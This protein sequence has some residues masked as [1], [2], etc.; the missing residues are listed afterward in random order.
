MSWKPP[1]DLN[2]GCRRGGREVGGVG[3]GGGG[4]N[5]GLEGFGDR[6][7]YLGS[8]ETERVWISVFHVLCSPVQLDPVLCCKHNFANRLGQDSSF[9]KSKGEKRIYLDFSLKIRKASSNPTEGIRT[10][11][12]NKLD[13]ELLFP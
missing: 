9:D 11:Q 6:S 4:D 13:S 1:P 7:T 5:G 12:P 8:S 3:G 10:G 2:S